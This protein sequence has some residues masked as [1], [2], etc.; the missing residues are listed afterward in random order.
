[1]EWCNSNSYD[2]DGRIVGTFPWLLEHTVPGH[3]QG[4]A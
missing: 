3:G 1:M 2:A 4:W